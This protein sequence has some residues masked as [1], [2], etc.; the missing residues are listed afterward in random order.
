MKIEMTAPVA[1]AM[2]SASSVPLTDKSQA[3]V[4]MSFF[5]GKDHQANTP[6]PNDNEVNIKEQVISTQNF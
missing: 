5:V 2:S 1:M 3:D 4:T 6:V